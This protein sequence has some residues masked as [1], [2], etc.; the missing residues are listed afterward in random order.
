M[1]KLTTKQKKLLQEIDEIRNIAYGYDESMTTYALG[2]ERYETIRNRVLS[3]CV[4]IEE[5]M[6]IFIMDHILSDSKRW[7]SIKYFGRIKRFLVLSDEILSRISP[8]VKYNILNKFLKKSKRWHQ[9]KK[10]L[11]ELFNLRNTFAHFYTI[12]YTKEKR[13]TYKKRDIFQT[14]TFKEYRKDMGKV[15]DFFIKPL[16]FGKQ[17]R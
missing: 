17:G 14:K 9:V 7:K 10:I 2:L 16:Y 5:A 8:F 12:D 13:G 6:G 15:F 3:D 1:G 11:P 4:L